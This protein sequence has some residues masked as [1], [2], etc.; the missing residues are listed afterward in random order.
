MKRSH[1]VLCLLLVG[2]VLAAGGVATFIRQRP[3]VSTAELFP[4]PKVLALIRLKS[5]LTDWDRPEIIW[6]GPKSDTTNGSYFEADRD[7]NHRCLLIVDSHQSPI[8]VRIIYPASENAAP[9]ARAIVAIVTP[10]VSTV[11]RDEFEQRFVTIAEQKR[12]ATIRF[13]GFDYEVGEI[14]PSLRLIGAH[15]VAEGR[16]ARP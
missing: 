6:K 1:V 8:G 4:H 3:R 2:L 7:L 15:K 10:P 12:R 14:Q 5:I 11:D 13:S 16:Q 9:Y